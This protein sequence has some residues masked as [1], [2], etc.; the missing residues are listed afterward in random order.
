MKKIFL[1]IIILLFAFMS[2]VAKSEEPSTD[3]NKY[4]GEWI[5]SYAKIAKTSKVFESEDFIGY[6]SYIEN[7]VPKK[8]LNKTKPNVEDCEAVGVDFM[9]FIRIGFI[10][11]GE[12]D[13]TTQ[14]AVECMGGM[15]ALGSQVDRMML[16]NTA[17]VH[18]HFVMMG[19]QMN[20]VFNFFKESSVIMSSMTNK[21]S[22]LLNKVATGEDKD[23]IMKSVTIC[24]NVF[25]FNV[26]RTF[27]LIEE[28]L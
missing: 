6:A 10:L 3:L 9:K 23:A 20:S 13:F 11:E 21:A 5:A 4:C 7:L 27:A 22:E 24:Q 26:G 16:S 19:K 14:K 28:G 25:Q 15:Y 17:A 18:N 1:P 8:K 2:S 12:D